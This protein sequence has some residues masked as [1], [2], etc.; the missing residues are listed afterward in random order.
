MQQQRQ[1]QIKQSRSVFWWLT[2]LFGLG[3]SAVGV[4]LWSCYIKAPLTQLLW[5]APVLG[6]IGFF[7]KLHPLALLGFSASALIRLL[8]LG[9]WALMP[10]S[11]QHDQED[12]RFNLLFS[13][14]FFLIDLLVLIGLRQSRR[15]QDG[16]P[17]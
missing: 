5:L 10:S 3:S 16:E 8:L 15:S 13:T 4:Y 17:L 12:I 9:L 2:L 7:L 14:I 11:G 6:L 1:L